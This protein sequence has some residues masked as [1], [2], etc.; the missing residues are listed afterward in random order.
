MSVQSPA[1]RGTVLKPYRGGVLKTSLTPEG[2][3]SPATAWLR[4]LVSDWRFWALVGVLPLFAQSFQY[5]VDVAP[6]YALTKA[7]P[8]LTLPLAFWA[9]MRLALPYRVI[10]LVTIAWMM[11]VTPLIGVFELGDTI[12]AALATTAKIWSLAIALSAAAVFVLLKVDSKTLSRVTLGWGVITFT[13]LVALWL[14]VPHRVYDDGANSTKLFLYDEQRGYRIYM[15]M[16]FGSIL[17]FALNR[18]FWIKPKVW[19]PVAMLI[20]FVLLV[21]IYK[22]R[23][24]IGGMVFVVILGA[25]FSLRRWRAP[26]LA[27]LAVAVMLGVPAV[28]AYAH[29]S[30]V[31]KS[32]GGSLTTR[33]AEI[34]KAI[35]FLNAQPHRWIF[36]SGSATRVGDVSLGDIV[37]TRVFFL[38]D[39]GW[40]GV[41]FEYGLIGVGLLLLLHWA[42]LKITWRAARAPAAVPRAV[43]DYVVYIVL[44]SP[45]LPVTFAPG[46][47]M[48]CMA[49]AFCFLR[50]GEGESGD[51]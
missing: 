40:L 48:T 42:A 49:M 1:P 45:I 2:T 37:G 13:A 5:V 46:E 3:A 50:N 25:L 31:Q 16:F 28:W 18:S 9:C 32:L 15:P 22:Q 21:M 14:V 36:G 19:K 38:A 43:F 41:T 17:V 51:S 11:G 27:A 4:G 8:I 12:A 33:Q 10:L 39:L 7:W 24:A 34:T 6:V 47:A 20:C 30:S 35:E 26:A 44:V 23:T 29:S